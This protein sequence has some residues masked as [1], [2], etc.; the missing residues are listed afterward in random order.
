[1]SV[2]GKTGADETRSRIRDD[3]PQPGIAADKID[4]NLPMPCAASPQRRSAAIADASRY[5]VVRLFTPPSGVNPSGKVRNLM[6]PGREIDRG[7]S[8]RFA[9]RVES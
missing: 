5:S 3:H 1:V 9:E 7:V 6:L 2:N 4:V 8:S